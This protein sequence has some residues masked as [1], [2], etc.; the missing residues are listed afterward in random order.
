MQI[1]GKSCYQK[2]FAWLPEICKSVEACWLGCVMTRVIVGRAKLGAI[3]TQHFLD[4]CCFIAVAWP[5]LCALTLNFFTG[6]LAFSVKS[7]WLTKLTFFDCLTA[8]EYVKIISPAQILARFCKLTLVTC[9]SSVLLIID[10]GRLDEHWLGKD[11]AGPKSNHGFWWA[12]YWLSLPDSSCFSHFH[13]GSCDL[14]EQ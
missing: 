5:L 1:L 4:F 3:S 8:R 9:M 14:T 12:F 10:F 7:W 11:V 13:L 6:L 2:F